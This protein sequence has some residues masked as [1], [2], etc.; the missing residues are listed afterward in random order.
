M[1][2]RHLLNFEHFPSQSS[3]HLAAYGSQNTKSNLIMGIQ[4][5]TFYAIC[6]FF[7]IIITLCCCV[8]IAIRRRRTLQDY[9]ENPER[10]PNLPDLSYFQ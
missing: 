10:F 3:I 5:P 6:G 2:K 7:V 8:I 1:L 9:N 4:A